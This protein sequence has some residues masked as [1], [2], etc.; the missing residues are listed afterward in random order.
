VVFKTS[1]L[2][3]KIFSSINDAFHSSP[4]YYYGGIAVAVL[5]AVFLV[6]CILTSCKKLTTDLV[7][8]KFRSGKNKGYKRVSTTGEEAGRNQAYNT[9]PL[10]HFKQNNTIE[11]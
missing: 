4:Y 7:M 2:Q 11:L 1:S 3:L 5:V 6:C 9:I 10:K 8:S